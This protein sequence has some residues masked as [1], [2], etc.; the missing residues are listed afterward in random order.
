MGLFSGSFGTGL[1]TGLA[2][3]V[4]ASLK[5]AMEKRDEEMS[6]ARTF[7]QTRQAQKLDQAEARD[8]RAGDALDRLI[9]EFGGDVAK[10]LAAYEGLGG[11]VEAVESYITEIDKTRDAG[12]TYDLN[13]KI[14]FDGIDLSQFADLS[15]EDAFGSIR[16]EIKPLDIQMSDMSGLSKIGLGMDN[17]GQQV[18][19]YVNELI[20]E[21]TKTTITGLTGA[22]I[23][24]SG[25]YT[26]LMADLDARSKVGNIGQQLATNNYMLETG[27]D[28]QNNPLTEDDRI[29]LEE[30]QTN[31]LI[32]RSNIAKS[33]AAGDDNSAAIRAATSAL[34][35]AW[36]R[37]QSMWKEDMGY[38]TSGGTTTAIIGGEELVGEAAAAAYQAEVT[39]R[40]NDWITNNLLD[41]VGEF[42]QGG[43]EMASLYGLTNKAEAVQK[44]IKTALQQESATGTEQGAGSEQGATEQ[45][46]P[47]AASATE[48]ETPAT[49]AQDT[50]GGETTTGAVVGTGDTVV[51]TEQ[52]LNDYILNNTVDYIQAAIANQPNLDPVLLRDK[53]IRAGVSPADADMH[54]AILVE[55]KSPVDIM[56]NPPIENVSPMPSGT[57]QAAQWR[58]K[59]GQTH[60][61]DGTPK[62]TVREQ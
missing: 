46:T 6:R 8:Q 62:Q 20:P 33:D 59:Y 45:E 24:R 40:T 50:T 23:D 58:A 14:K 60:N 53:L 61:P 22:V 48:Q 18:S 1:V 12:M 29:R 13:E 5:S 38:S 35:T 9:K 27:R 32:L 51:S 3:S 11:S 39:R 2:T 28:M 49:T 7:W 16:T 17:M 47:E 31:L 54:I 55:G 42:V 21:R 10:G 37:I 19:Q 43:A 56:N 44:S 34:G 36:S 26:G 25:T 52:E 4:D 15:R 57:R 41:E 30:T